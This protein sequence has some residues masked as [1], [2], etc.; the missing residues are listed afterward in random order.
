MRVC[1]ARAEPAALVRDRI[2][3]IGPPSLGM[4]ATTSILRL[5]TRG[6]SRHGSSVGK[7]LLPGFELG[8]PNRPFGRLRWTRSCEAASGVAA[9]RTVAL[10]ARRPVIPVKCPFGPPSLK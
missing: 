9:A 5:D 7:D 2:G 1:A 8:R 10:G 6:G 3:F 4:P